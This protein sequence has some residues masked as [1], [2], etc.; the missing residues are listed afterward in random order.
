MGYDLIG[1]KMY[2]IYIDDERHPKNKTYVVC[3]T[4]DD[5]LKLIK[6]RGLPIAFSMDHDLG[7]NKKTGYD[8]IKEFVDYIIHE[9][10]FEDFLKIEW[11]Y[12]TA[13]PIGK[14][15]M[16]SYIKTFTNTVKRNFK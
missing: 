1:V 3:R 12:H 6:E 14:I 8:F 11:N 4:V 9:E 10:L 5:A 15:N 7:E 16:E 13:N 2:K